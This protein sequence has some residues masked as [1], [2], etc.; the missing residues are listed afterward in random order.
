MIMA[1][2]GGESQ[3]TLGHEVEDALVRLVRGFCEAAVLE[4][5]EALRCSLK[6]VGEQGLNVA[7]SSQSGPQVRRRKADLR[8]HAEAEFS[9]AS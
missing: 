8:R 5:G 3:P 6:A 7:G 1:L 2:A 9:S 4:A